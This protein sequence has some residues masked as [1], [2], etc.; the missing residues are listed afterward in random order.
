L[1]VASLQ[2]AA[3]FSSFVASRQSPGQTPVS[4]WNPWAPL[5]SRAAFTMA[6]IAPWSPAAGMICFHPYSLW[7]AL[8]ASSSW[9]ISFQ[10]CLKIW[11]PIR[12]R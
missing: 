8:G 2:R 12:P 5:R 1:D 7:R 4:F 10:A 3:F 11:P 9:A 6:K